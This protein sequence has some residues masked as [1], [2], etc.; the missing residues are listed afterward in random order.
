MTTPAQKIQQDRYMLKGFLSGLVSRCEGVLGSNY[1]SMSERIKIA[2]I[3]D[4]AKCVLERFSCSATAV[5]GGKHA[6]R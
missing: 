4:A 2:V 3:R 1:T 6:K 5:N